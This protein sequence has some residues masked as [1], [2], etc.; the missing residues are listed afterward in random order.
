[1][2]HNESIPKRKTHSPEC[3]QKEAGVSIPYQPKISRTKGST[4]KRSRQQEIIKLKTEINQVETKRTI[5]R[6][7]QT[8]RTCFANKKAERVCYL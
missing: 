6:I 8:R 3:V 4:P 7:N 1:M 2:G 5:Q